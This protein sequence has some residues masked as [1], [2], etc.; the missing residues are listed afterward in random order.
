MR[1]PAAFPG[2]GPLPGCCRGLRG[3][4]A[5][6]SAL[7]AVPLAGRA[8]RGPG[9][10]TGRPDVLGRVRVVPG[11]DGG[12]RPDAVAAA[13]ALPDGRRDCGLPVPWPVRGDRPAPPLPEPCPGCWR[14]PAALVAPGPPA[15]PPEPRRAVPAGPVLPG[16][17]PPDP[18]PP[19]GPPLGVGGR[20]PRREPPPPGG[21]RPAPPPRPDRT[22]ATRRSTAAANTNRA[23]LRMGL[24]PRPCQTC[25]PIQNGIRIRMYS[26]QII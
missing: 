22:G 14:P 17:A 10:D 6:G 25:R 4:G 20:F 7:R 15:A 16:P 3:G 11:P 24:R 5:G 21:R 9:G 23:A 1:R 12:V 26:T 18:P 13:Q 19:R 2:L 8:L